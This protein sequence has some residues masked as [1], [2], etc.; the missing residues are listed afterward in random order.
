MGFC[1]A[2]FARELTQALRFLMTVRLD[3]EI[4]EAHST[5]LVRPGELTTMKRDLLRDSFQ[6]VKRLREVVRRHFNLA[7]F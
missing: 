6:M 4:A 2:Q 5:S 1:D 3:A 7:T